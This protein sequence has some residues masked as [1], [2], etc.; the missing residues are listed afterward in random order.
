MKKVLFTLFL[1]FSSFLMAQESAFQDYLDHFK[2]ETEDSVF[3][4]TIVS[5]SLNDIF[6][7]N[8]PSE[9]VEQFIDEFKSGNDQECRY[10]YGIK[11]NLHAYVVVFVIRD[12]E[13]FVTQW[14]RGIQECLAIVYSSEGEKKSSMLLC[15]RSD[16]QSFRLS[17]LKSGN[18]I[19]NRTLLG[20]SVN[21]ITLQKCLREKESLFQAVKYVRNYDINRNGVI[22]YVGQYKYSDVNV[23]KRK[24]FTNVVEEHEVWR[25]I[26]DK[27]I[28]ATPL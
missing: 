26:W 27:Y 23:I 2:E 24:D 5:D 9:Y 20:M 21:E 15:K 4:G 18:S 16:G 19:P 8:I 28:K 13:D 6:R 3:C 22:L 11:I 14:G 7:E 1:S 10:F 25:E 12:S 17:C